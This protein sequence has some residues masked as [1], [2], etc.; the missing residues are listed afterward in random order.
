MGVGVGVGVRVRVGVRV[1]VE[2]GVRI[3]LILKSIYEYSVSLARGSKCG[4]EVS[5]SQNLPAMK[6]GA[7][8]N[9]LKGIFLLI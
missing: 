8:H 5:N 7:S 3:M 1:G 6:V 4:L 9:L 2:V